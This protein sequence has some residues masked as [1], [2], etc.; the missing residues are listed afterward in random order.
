MNSSNNGKNKYNGSRRHLIDRLRLEGIHDERVLEAMESVPRDLFVLEEMKDSSYIDTPL[1]IQA[2]QTISQPY[3]V[4]SMT[5]TLIQGPK[6]PR[7]VLEVGTGS[8]YQTAI[9]AHVVEEVYSIERIKELADLAKSRIESLGLK[10][11]K[12]FY[13][14]GIQGLEEYAPFDG[15][16]VTAAPKSVP[17]PLQQQLAIGGRMIIPVG[18]DGSQ[19][20]VLIVRKEKGFKT[21]FL[22]GVRFV[23]LLKGTE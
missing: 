4:A 7:K 8:G 1:P 12:L 21:S 22:E 2:K 15:I 3:I 18:E 20:L 9:L 6:P 17:E 14:D 10:N 16:I 13:G 19:R 23:P 5:Q 11:V